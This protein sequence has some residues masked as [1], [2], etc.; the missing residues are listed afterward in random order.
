MVNCEVYDIK[1][2]SYEHFTDLP[3]MI[4]DFGL[5]LVGDSTVF[6]IGGMDPLTFETKPD[7]YIY[8]LESHQWRYDFPKL[9]TAR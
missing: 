1:S 9:N 5:V 8:D 3:A 2:D 7:V 6:L 4:L